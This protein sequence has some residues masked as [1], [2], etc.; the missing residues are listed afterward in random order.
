MGIYSS[1]AFQ[2]PEPS[3]PFPRFF[4]LSNAQG[5]SL[6]SSATKFRYKLTILHLHSLLFRDFSPSLACPLTTKIGE[7]RE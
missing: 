6:S 2:T 1:V 4:I 3:F 7:G 5:T